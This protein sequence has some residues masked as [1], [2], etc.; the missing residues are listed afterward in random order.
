MDI[1]NWINFGIFCV[2][3]L[4][5]I[6]TWIATRRSARE[7]NSAQQEAN[8]AAGRSAAAA[9]RA[10]QQQGR[11]VEIENQRQHDA[12]LDASKARL[13]ATVTEKP[14]FR[15]NKPA[16]DTY[17]TII[18]TGSAAASGVEILV[19]GKSLAEHAE[20]LTQLP[21]DPSIGANGKLDI[22]F[23]LL[24]EGSLRRPFTVDIR[25]RDDSELP[26]EWSGTVT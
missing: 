4:V 24:M 12:A 7:A 2:T 11:I 5:G 8:A 9:E 14:R 16:N 18:N 25:W 15:F 6:L 23:T 1:S 22:L 17:L 20:F 21:S 3:A 19:D 10:V 13:H 26:G